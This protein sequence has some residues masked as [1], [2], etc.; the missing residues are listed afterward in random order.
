MNI[1]SNQNLLMHEIEEK[2]EELLCKAIEERRL[3]KFYY[4]SEKSKKKE[5]R[6]AQPYNVGIKE[7]GNV[8]LAALPISELRKKI[9]DCVTGH[10]WLKKM[11]IK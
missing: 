2:V 1:N 4:E 3:L 6:I 9:Q 10:Y 11:D 8:F 7:N 5:W